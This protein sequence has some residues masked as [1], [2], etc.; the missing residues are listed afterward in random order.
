MSL[1]HHNLPFPQTVMMWGVLPP[2]KGGGSPYNVRLQNVSSLLRGQRTEVMHALSFSHNALSW[3][4]AED[5]PR[6]ERRENDPPFFEL[7]YCLIPEAWYEAWQP[8]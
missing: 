3:L 7:C 8:E 1:Q 6:T 4:W 5:V 2:A